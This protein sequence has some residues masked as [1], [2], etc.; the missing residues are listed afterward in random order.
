VPTSTHSESGSMQKMPTKKQTRIGSAAHALDRLHQQVKAGQKSQDA[1]WEPLRRLSYSI[2]SN[3]LRNLD[4]Y[5]EVAEEASE[6]VWLAL[7]GFRAESKLSTWAWTIIQ[8][9]AQQ[10]LR[11]QEKRLKAEDQLDLRQHESIT[12]PTS[13]TG[14]THTINRQSHSQL[15]SKLSGRKRQCME[16]LLEGYTRLEIA[17][18]LKI[19]YDGVR[20]YLRRAAKQL[21]KAE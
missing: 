12:T 11:A 18:Q 14:S 5:P 20:M 9:H 6:A 19:S 21:K 16:L 8:R 1:L 17:S 3:K 15:L 4:E 10:W 13:Q 2:I 7:S